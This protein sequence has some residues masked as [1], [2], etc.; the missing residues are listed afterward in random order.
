[1]KVINIADGKARNSRVAMESKKRPKFT[2]YT[3]SQNQGV[4]SARIVKNT[5]ATD[6]KTLTKETSLEDLSQKLIDGDPELD[7][8]LFGKRIFDTS[9]IYLNSNNEPA[10]GVNLKELIYSPEGELKEQRDAKTVEGNINTEVPLKWSGKLMPKSECYKKFVFSNAYQIKHV[11]GLTFDFLFNMAKELDEQN[12]M[13]FLGAGK[14]NNEPLIISRNG[15]QFRAFLEGRV[16]DSKFMLILHLT[17]L[18]MK[19]VPVAEQ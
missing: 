4:E 2:R 5:L 13:M 15:K 9:R 18:E 7:I 19:P 6:L 14:K 17:N 8:E 10:G 11:D 1:M 3:D 16:Q 12:A